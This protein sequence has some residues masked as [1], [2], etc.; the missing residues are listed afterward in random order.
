MGSTP[1]F[2]TYSELRAVLA[3]YDHHR[4]LRELSHV[5]S[6]PNR[7][8]ALRL[9]Y[10]PQYGDSTSIQYEVQESLRRRLLAAIIEEMHET[11]QTLKARGYT[12]EEATEQ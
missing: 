2:G 3:L 5:L 12:F 9:N 10:Q 1:F 6:V 7:V 11:E 4:K 8:S